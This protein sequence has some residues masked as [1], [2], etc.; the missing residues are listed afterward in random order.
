MT[1]WVVLDFIDV[2][3]HVMNED[4]RELYDLE[5]LWGDGKK[6]DLSR[7][8]PRGLPKPEPPIQPQFRPAKGL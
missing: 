2:I 6:I 4:F 5:N 1:P 8:P 3:V 7:N